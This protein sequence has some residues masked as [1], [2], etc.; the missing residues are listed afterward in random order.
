MTIVDLV[1]LNDHDAAHAHLDPQAKIC[2]FVGR[3]LTHT[4]LPLNPDFAGVYAEVFF[5]RPLARFDDL[6][7]TQTLPAGPL[8]VVVFAV[9]GVR[10]AWAQRCASL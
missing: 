8:T 1:G 6:R 7:Y 2:H 4:V 3:G 5:L 9:E 10:P